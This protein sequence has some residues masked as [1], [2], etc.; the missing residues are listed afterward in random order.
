[1]NLTTNTVVMSSIFLF[2]GWW[3][4]NNAHFSFFQ[5]SIPVVRRLLNY[6]SP[7]LAV[8]LSGEN[9]SLV[10]RKRYNLFKQVTTIHY[11]I[12]FKIKP[13]ILHSYWDSAFDEE[14]LKN[15]IGTK[16]LYNQFRDDYKRYWIQPSEQQI[17]PLKR[18]MEQD[19]QQEVMTICLCSLL[20]VK[21]YS[22]EFLFNKMTR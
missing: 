21:T 13:Y 10:M 1:M 19:K 5:K 14:L 12:Y 4:R 9:A 8:K 15:V 17:I 22:S 2:F 3:S 6:E 18:L 11:D 7:F 20:A 16:L